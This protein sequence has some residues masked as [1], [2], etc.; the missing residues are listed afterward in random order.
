LYFGFGFVIVLLMQTNS[1]G[2]GVADHRQTVLL[3]DDDPS[4]QRV[5]GRDLRVRGGFDV[6]GAATAEEALEQ[7]DSSK[8]AVLLDLHLRGRDDVSGVELLG[9]IRR[10]GYD[11][12]I[13]VLTGDK[14]PELLLSCVEAGADGYLIKP[15]DAISRE[16]RRGING[17]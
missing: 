5:V 3:V 7:S 12:P 15:C 6:V 4:I 9:E 2:R 11:H 14:N 10:R 13:S 1:P 17:F 8:D 16:I